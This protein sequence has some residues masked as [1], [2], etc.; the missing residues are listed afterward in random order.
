MGV[1]SEARGLLL[2]Y[3]RNRRVC[4]SFHYDRP[5]NMKKARRIV[6]IRHALS[7]EGMA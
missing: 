6:S 5:R 2:A 4:N 3:Y 7:S 1:P